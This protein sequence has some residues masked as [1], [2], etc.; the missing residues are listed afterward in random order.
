[1]FCLNIYKYEAMLQ[2]CYEPTVL[3]LIQNKQCNPMHVYLER[4][5]IEFSGANSQDSVYC[6]SLQP[7]P[8]N[9]TVDVSSHECIISILA[10]EETNIE[11]LVWSQP[12]ESA[13]GQRLSFPWLWEANLAGKIPCLLLQAIYTVLALKQEIKDSSKATFGI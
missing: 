12:L 1:M 6:I 2:R 8:C 13:L 3:A 5:P 10:V 11:K 4:N 9:A 7:Q